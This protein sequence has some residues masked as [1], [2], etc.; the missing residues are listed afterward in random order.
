MVHAWVVRAGRSDEYASEDLEHSMIAMGWRRLQDLTEHRTLSAISTAVNR[1]YGEFSLRSR[2]SYA[3]QM[4]AFR[5]HMRPGDYVV[6]LRSKAPDVAVGIV[7][8]DY[9]YR[10]ELPVHHV[11][12]VQWTRTDVRRTEIGADLLAAP[13]LT[14]IYRVNQSNAAARLKVVAAAGHSADS[15]QPPVFAGSAA[16]VAVPAA[17]VTG[18]AGNFR[19]NLD[20]ALS[21][22]TAGLHLQQLKVEAFEVSDV[23]RAAWVQAIAALDHWV[24]QEIH[25]RMLAH[26]LTPPTGQGPSVHFQLPA[27][28]VDQ[29]QQGQLTVAAAVTRHFKKGLGGMPFVQPDK[30]CKGLANV[31][32]VTDLWPRVAVVL[33]ERAGE[34]GSTYSGDDVQQMLKEIVFRRNKIA[35]END[36]D[37]EHPPAKR[38]IDAA[39]TTQ[40]IEWIGKLSEAIRLV[41]DEPS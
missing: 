40:T 10:P 32:D 27:A 24:H 33:S 19:R 21:L 17:A 7:T 35:H 30:I 9:A 13:A 5:C 2:Q 20:Y 25:Q 18:P 14:N 34:D 28:L 39:S 4:Y 3:V 31:V 26:A 22:A 36:E 38:P 8:G 16:T 37:P 1:A 12:D 29:I 15:T 41:I 6:L 23:F 11:R